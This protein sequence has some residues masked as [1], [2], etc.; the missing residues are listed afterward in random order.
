MQL[1]IVIPVYNNWFLTRRCLEALDRLRQAGRVAFEVIVVDNASND[2]TPEAIAR[3]PWVR[4][5]RNETNQNFAG[6]CNAGVAMAQAPLVLLLNNDA[7]PLGDALSPLVAAFERPEVA[8]AGGALFFEDGVTQA[9]ALVLLRNAH[10]HY[11]YRNLPATLV[12]VTAS[13]DALAV[14][15]AAMAVRTRWF[16]E[17][18]GFDESFVNGFEDVDLCMHASEAK[19]AIAYVASARFAH[20]E[21]ASAGR[22]DHEVQNELRFYARWASRLRSLPRTQRGEVGALA[23][24]SERFAGPLLAAALEDLAA[25]LRSF[26]HPVVHGRLPKLRWFDRRFRR[27]ASIAWFSPKVAEPGITIERRANLPAS[28]RTLGAT[29]L[30]VPWLACASPERVSAC[31]VRRSGAPQC[32]IVGFAGPAESFAGLDCGYPSVLITPQMLLGEE[33]VEVACVVHAGLT[34]DAA[35]GNVLLAQA[36]VPAVVLPNDE[37]RTIFA[38]DTA[39]FVAR[40]ALRDAVDRFVNDVSSRE[41]Y[42]R[43]VAADSKRRFSPRRSAIRVVDV[44]CAARFGLE[45]PATA[46]SNAPF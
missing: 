30:D 25:G 37:L 41:R 3:I 8:I 2:E 7:Y 9:A 20:Y 11:S 19:K 1:S 14:S 28:M 13:R 26:G 4:Y 39:V 17:S 18:G 35:F 5:R 21:A 40:A 31:G 27:S 45:R 34:D 43:L 42:G 29:K 10:W 23:I 22:F 15:G 6:A 38:G 24:A 32:R 36:G 44:L 46:R 33:A 16:L 12:G